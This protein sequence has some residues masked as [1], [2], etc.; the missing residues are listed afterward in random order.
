[1]DTVNPVLKSGF[2]WKYKRKYCHRLYRKLCIK[3][4]NLEGWAVLELLPQT[5]FCTFLGAK[6][7]HIYDPWIEN[8]QVESSLC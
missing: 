7:Q 5:K 6:P 3:S 4:V 8:D 1:L 2:W